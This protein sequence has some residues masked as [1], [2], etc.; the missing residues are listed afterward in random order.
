MKRFRTALDFES[1]KVG[2]INHTQLKFQE[3]AHLRYYCQG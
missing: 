3:A 2:T 1:G